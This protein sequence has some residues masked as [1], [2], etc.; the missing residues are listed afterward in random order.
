MH[1]ECFNSSRLIHE[2]EMEIN[3]QSYGQILARAW[4]REQA[5]AKQIYVDGNDIVLN[6]RYEYRVPISRCNTVLGSTISC[7]R[8]IG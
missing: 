7:T 1:I 6:V 8:R 2:A 4:E 3:E 5:I